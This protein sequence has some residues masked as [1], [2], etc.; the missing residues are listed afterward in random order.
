MYSVKTRLTAVSF[1]LAIAAAIFLLVWPVYSGFN[2]DQPPHASLLQVNGPSA[3]IPVLFP[4]LTTLMPLLLRKQ[5][6][7]IIATVLI[8][9]FA[10]IGGFSI[11]FF[12]LPA[13]IVM[14]LASCVVESRS[15][16]IPES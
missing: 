11:G 3:I 14:L 12:Y 1:G 4:V 10:L 15:S 16:V 9:G 2:G 8:G 6:V 5:W 13:G 7:R